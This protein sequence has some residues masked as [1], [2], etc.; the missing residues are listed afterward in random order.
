MVQ[1]IQVELR[2]DTTHT[3]TWLD[4]TLVPKAGM[5]LL[6]DG[7]PRPWTVMHAY[8]IASELKDVSLAWRVTGREVSIPRRLRFR[9]NRVANAD[10]ATV[11]SGALR[12]TLSRTT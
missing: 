9:A 1:A 6:R 3:L 11:A 10:H 7:D 2:T 8:C 12:R 4:A 5:V